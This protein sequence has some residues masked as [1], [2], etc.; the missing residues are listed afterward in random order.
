LPSSPS[1]LSWPLSSGRSS[2]QNSGRTRPI[3]TQMD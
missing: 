2:C 1:W 3:D